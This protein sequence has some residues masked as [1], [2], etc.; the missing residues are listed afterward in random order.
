[1]PRIRKIDIRVQLKKNLHWNTGLYGLMDMEDDRTFRLEVDY[2]DM[3]EMIHTIM[4]EMVHVKQYLRKELVQLDEV[5]VWKNVAFGKYA[6]DY[7]KRVKSFK[8]RYI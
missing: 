3:D 6:E 7:R 4:H 2:S 8:E 5:Y 1:M